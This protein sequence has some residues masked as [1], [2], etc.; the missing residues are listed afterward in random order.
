VALLERTVR[1][2]VKLDGVQCFETFSD[3]AHRFSFATVWLMVSVGRMV[4]SHSGDMAL[5]FA[6]TI[7][8][9]P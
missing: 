4:F 5:N 3:D 8:G 6:A 9:N 1:S 2:A 7:G